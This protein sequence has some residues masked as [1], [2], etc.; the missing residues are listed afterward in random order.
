MCHN[1]VTTV[2]FMKHMLTNL[3]VWSLKIKTDLINYCLVSGLMI[4]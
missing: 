2:I 1:L 4:F 3:H